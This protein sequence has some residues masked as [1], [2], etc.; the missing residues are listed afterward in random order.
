LGKVLSIAT[1]R[2]GSYLLSEESRRHYADPALELMTLDFDFIRWLIGSPTSVSATAVW[3]SGLAC[4]AEHT[5][6]NIDD[7][8]LRFRRQCNGGG[9]RHHAKGVPFL[10]RFQSSV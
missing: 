10:N 4:E 1:Y 6:R 5:R 9:E 8:E 7:L 2:L 3:W